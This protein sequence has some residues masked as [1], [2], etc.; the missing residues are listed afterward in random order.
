MTLRPLLNL[1]LVA[2]LTPATLAQ[3]SDAGS[4]PPRFIRVTSKASLIHLGSLDSFDITESGIK[5]ADLLLHC[6]TDKRPEP[7]REAIEIYKRIIPNENFG[8]EYTALEWIC[9]FMVAS[10]AD[11]QKMLADRV[12]AEWYKHLAQ[13]DF[14]PLKY[15]L[16]SKYHLREWKDRK[17]PKSEAKFRFLEDFILFNNPRRE[18]WEQ[19]SKMMEVLGLKKGDVVAD[20][21]SGP[22]YFT[23]KFA[24]LVGD[25]GYV[26]AIDT[27]KQHLEYVARLVREFG[28]K[29][30]E[31][32]EA[33]PK[34]YT[35][36][37]KVDLVYVCSLYHNIYALDTDE[38]RGRFMSAIK[39]MLKP[40][41]TLVLVDNGLVED[42][43]LPYHG[44]HIAKELIINQLWYYGWRLVQT[45]Q[46][47]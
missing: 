16:K 23:F 21:G 6:L 22:G 46:F 28:L 3:Q 45:H 43:T 17:T 4:G 2:V 20:L 32:V 30:V 13:N 40:G 33:T 37:K 8:G 9:E 12:T 34:G 35:L 29:N 14:E 47:I 36:G 7:A 42:K 10:K 31:A 24:N 41:G 19:T 39:D 26:Y 5:A 27:N 15:Y 25:T 44:P 38:E 1:C 18:R 11:Q